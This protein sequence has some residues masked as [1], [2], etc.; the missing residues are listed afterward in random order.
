M[1]NRAGVV[2]LERKQRRMKKKISPTKN[3]GRKK[4]GMEWKRI[5]NRKTARLVAGMILRLPDFKKCG[6]LMPV[7]IQDKT[8]GTVLMLAYSR[9]K[10]FWETFFT[11]EVVFYS[12]SRKKRWKKGEEKSG[13]VLLVHE[14]LLDCDGD[15]LLYIV[16]Q[17]NP[18]AGSCHIGAPTCFSPIITSVFEQKGNTTLKVVP[19]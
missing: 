7:I 5:E 17:K 8:T 15:T 1:S 9:A 19:L 13:N 11:H 3:P 6:G 4:V 16:T 14:I 10:E 2:K 12:R 18:D